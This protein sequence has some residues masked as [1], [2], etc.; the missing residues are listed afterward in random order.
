MLASLAAVSVAAGP[1]SHA[2]PVASKRPHDQTPHAYAVAQS[3]VAQVPASIACGSRGILWKRLAVGRATAT[4]RST[5][6]GVRRPQM[7]DGREGAGGEIGQSSSDC[8]LLRDP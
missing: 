6:S 2:H 8:D 1:A 4:A 5:D 7:T 3:A